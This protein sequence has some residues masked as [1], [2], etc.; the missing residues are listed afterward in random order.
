[1]AKRATMTALQQSESSVVSTDRPAMKRID[2]LFVWWLVGLICATPLAVA[3]IGAVSARP[4]ADDYSL[5][6]KVATQGFVGTFSTYM[7]HWTPLYSMIGV[8]AG[9]TAMLGKNFIPVAS[10]GLLI[11]IVVVAGV[12]WRTWSSGASSVP[13]PVAAICISTGMVG[14]FASTHYPSAPILFG[15]LL[16]ATAWVPHVVPI[17]LAP[18][19]LLLALK[20]HGRLGV[21][22]SIIAGLATA[23]FGFVETAIVVSMVVMTRVGAVASWWATATTRSARLPHR[24]RCW[25]G[26]RSC[27]CLCPAGDGCSK[28][29]LRHFGSRRRTSSRS[30]H[31]LLCIARA[32]QFRSR[33][34]VACHTP[35]RGPRSHSQ[36]PS[37]VILSGHAPLSS[38]ALW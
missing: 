19:V 36:R 8:L 15:A 34:P 2:P 35:R 11:L 28:S 22:V 10:C 4:I 23:G 24:S 5:M 17:L 6:S 7:N 16:W 27:D 30:R 37:L 9:G 14:S 13:T 31:P 38:G 12:V 20:V 3:A 32:P 29:C 21:V 25:P 18:L 33:R 26:R 1:M